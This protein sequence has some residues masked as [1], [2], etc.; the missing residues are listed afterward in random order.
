MAR[1]GLYVRWAVTADKATA[2]ELEKRIITL[3]AGTGL[4]N[5]GRRT[6]L[7]KLPS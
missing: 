7:F 6:V 5:R 3:L 2:V 1:A 4:R